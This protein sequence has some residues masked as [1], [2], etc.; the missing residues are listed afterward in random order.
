MLCQKENGGIFMKKRIVSVALLLALLMSMFAGCGH[1]HSYGSWKEKE[2]AT[3]TQEGKRVRTCECGEKQKEDIPK[4][5][6]T[7]EEAV[8]TV[9]TCVTEGVKTFTC[10]ACGDSYTEAIA[11]GEHS[12]KDEVTKEPSCGN[13]GVKTFTCELCG[14]SYTEA[15]PVVKYSSTEISEKYIKSVGEVVVSDPKG[16]EISLGTCFV[17]SED[18]KLITNYHVIEFGYSAT[19][20]IDSQTY[21][22]S[23]VLAYDKD[24]D[25]AVLQIPATGLQAVTVCKEDH[26]TGEDV[27]AY[28]SP[29]GLTD[30]ISAG[31]ISSEPR[32][33][34][35]VKYVQHSAPISSGNSGGPLIS[36]YGEVI[37]INTWTV[38][39]S[40]NLNFAIHLS[41]LDAL[42][43][44][45]PM[46]MAEYYEKECDPYTR[47]KNYIINNGSYDSDGFYVVELG[48]S[49]SSDYT[50]TYKREAYYYI[51]SGNVTLDMV[52]NSG[53]YW[54]YFVIA[55]ESNGTYEWSYFD[56][57]DYSMGGTL[58]ASTFTGSTLAYNRNNINNSALRDA[59]C[60]LATSMIGAICQSIDSDLAAA[61]VTAADLLFQYF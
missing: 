43:Y 58:H 49:Y 26:K 29:K 17:Y 16:S 12:Y 19:V 57:D 34:D 28:G 27:Y 21:T 20:T 52:I 5:P 47:L 9:A 30:T 40:Q 59:I 45:S 2:K 4:D 55:P 37:G 46:T 15:I 6:H 42:D 61:G 18:G 41:E 44:S 10:T 54:C 48:Y 32:V 38:R 31:I 35:G 22:V 7:Y 33:L 39:E 51:E 13:E 25:I 8:T 36:C 60:T 11:K 14:D 50:N 3:C 56:D 53:E 24:K 1:E 23:Q